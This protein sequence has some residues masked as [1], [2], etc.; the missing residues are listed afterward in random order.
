MVTNTDFNSFLLG[1][2]NIFSLCIL[3]KKLVK[4][5]GINYINS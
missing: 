4:S 5:I 2:S 1:R 3:K